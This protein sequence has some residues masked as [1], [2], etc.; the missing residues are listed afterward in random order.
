MVSGLHGTSLGDLKN[1]WKLNGNGQSSFAQNPDVAEDWFQERL[2]RIQWDRY[3]PRIRLL[4]RLIRQMLSKHKS[5]RPSAQHILDY[6]SEIS[7]FVPEH[8]SIVTIAACSGRGACV[9]LSNPRS[10]GGHISSLAKYL[11]SPYKFSRYLYAL[12]LQDQGCW[13][14]DLEWNALF[15]KDYTAS[16]TAWSP[17]H[18]RLKL[19]EA[20]DLVYLRSS[21]TGAT[22]NFW[23]AHQR[24]GHR[25]MT[26]DGK[27][28]A[29]T[30]TVLILAKHV[31]F[32]K[33]ILEPHIIPTDEE[34]LV[35]PRFMQVT[36]LPVCLPRSQ[37]YGSFFWMLSW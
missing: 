25:T 12:Y 23:K 26:G 2:P 30:N 15:K 21:R 16:N 22:K 11:S 33:L 14:L 3:S 13:L 34:D 28:D 36:L 37:Y 19:Q 10:N 5:R 31:V 8:P 7:I 18:H 35:R 6:M 20:C 17:D 9:G 4:C 29:L 32:M 24:N 27:I 1:I